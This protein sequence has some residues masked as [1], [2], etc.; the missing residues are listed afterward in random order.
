MKIKATFVCAIASVGLASA[1]P[2]YAGTPNFCPQ[3]DSA[4]GSFL[5]RSP[6][7]AR[8]WWRSAR[9]PTRRAR[10]IDARPS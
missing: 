5:S 10:S 2:A 7:S 8:C 4:V 9:T 6:S 3:V 1:A